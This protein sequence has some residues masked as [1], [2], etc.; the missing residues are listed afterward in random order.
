MVL[1]TIKALMVAR[2]LLFTTKAKELLIAS[3]LPL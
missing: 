3:K 2:L 1:N